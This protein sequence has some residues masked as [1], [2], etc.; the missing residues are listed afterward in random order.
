MADRP[1]GSILV[2]VPAPSLHLFAGVRKRQEPV[3]VH[4]LGSDPAVERLCKSVV[5]WLAGPGEVERHAPRGSPQI[6]VARDGLAALVDPNDL[7]IADR[8]ADPFERLDDVLTPVAEP[9]DCQDFRV[10]AAIE[11]LEVPDGTTQGSPYS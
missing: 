1:M 4:A 11:E 5:G 6:E 2:V 9:R 3:R 8:R 7:R 10:R